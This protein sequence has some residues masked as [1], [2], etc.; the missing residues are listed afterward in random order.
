MWNWAPSDIKENARQ[1][2]TNLDKETIDALFKEINN[3][4]VKE[5]ENRFKEL[6]GNLKAAA[7]KILAEFPNAD[8]LMEYE[9]DDGYDHEVEILEA[10]AN[11]YC[12]PHSF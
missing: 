1:M 7:Q 4:R 11:G 12:S 6:Y 5:R 8:I 9:D 3:I 10:L 2:A